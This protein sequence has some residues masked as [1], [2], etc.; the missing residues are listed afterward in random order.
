MDVHAMSAPGALAE[1][2]STRSEEEREN[3]PLSS[4]RPKS[5][6]C[7]VGPLDYGC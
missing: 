6:F 2:Q 7:C 4:S 1:L 5:T 3:S